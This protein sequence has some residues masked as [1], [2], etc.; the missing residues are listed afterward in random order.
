MLD[1]ITIAVRDLHK[2]KQVFESVFKAEFIKNVELTEQNAVASY[3]RL[4]NVMIGLEAPLTEAGEIYNFLQKK[5][6]GIHHLAFNVENLAQLETDLQAHDI[7]LI[8]HS[9]KNGVKREFFTHPR[10][11]LGL[12]LQLMEWEEP[13]KNSFE[14]RMKTVGEG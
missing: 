4:G 13:Y 8:A 6:E 12:L 2:S 14:E 7:K 1:H 5:G 10:N 11:S 9:E 3:Y